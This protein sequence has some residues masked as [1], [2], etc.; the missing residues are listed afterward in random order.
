M[1]SISRVTMGLA[2]VLVCLAISGC[3]KGKQHIEEAT[4]LYEAGNID[5]ALERLRLVQQDAPKSKEVQQAKDLAVSWLVAAGDKTNDTEKKRSFLDRALQWDSKSGSAQV[6]ICEIHDQA[7]EIEPLVKCVNQDLADKNGVP[8][9]RAKPLRE[10][11]ERNRLL[12]SSD[13]KDWKQ[14]VEKYPDSKEAP[15]AW[16]KIDKVES[17]CVAAGN[18]SFYLLFAGPL[19]DFPGVIVEAYDALE[20][21]NALLGRKLLVGLHDQIGKLKDKLTFKCLE[22]Q[23]HQ[24]RPGEEALQMEFT[25]SC[26]KLREHYERWMKAIDNVEDL[27]VFVALKE[28]SGR[29]T[30]YF[31]PSVVSHRRKE[32][33]KSIG[34][35]GNKAAKSAGTP[36]E[37]T[38]T[39]TRDS[40]GA[41]MVLVPAGPFIRGS[42]DGDS[43]EQPIRKLTLSAFWIDKTE[44][45]TARYAKCVEA[46]GCTLASAG[47]ACNQGNASKADD[48]IN[49]VKWEQADAYCK[50]AGARLPTEAEWEKA[51]R[52]T[53]GRPYP[54]GVKDPSCDLAVWFDPATG[55]HSCGQF[56]TWLAGSKP[57]GAS[58]YGALDMAGNVWEWVADAYNAGYYAA[59]PETDPPGPAPGPYRVMRG[60]GWGYDGDGKLR[61]AERFKFAAGNQTPGTGFRCAMDAKASASA[62]SS[63]AP[64]PSAAPVP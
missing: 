43:D 34:R 58:P 42:D 45:T 4:K 14:I 41:E 13:I 57:A 40:D 25:V 37:T 64:A 7:D 15:E 54:W 17:L 28:E 24:F 44:V 12:A 38:E 9:D 49:C 8:D 33:C 55:Q 29:L 31:K 59:A 32:M 30:K 19:A 35:S 60:G 22:L 21:G 20:V 16:N 48:P 1:R 27:D 52:G 50:W 2:M 63:A 47:K 10:R 6:R 23:A 61:T 26:K 11:V 5:G 51:A 3:N 62:A 39:K 46:K 56:G 53:D 18:F 36:A